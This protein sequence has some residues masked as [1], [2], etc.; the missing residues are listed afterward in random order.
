MEKLVSLYPDDATYQKEFATLL[1]W[2]ADTSRSQGHFGAAIEAR[3][4]QIS[5]LEHVLAGTRDS[6]ARSKLMSAH[7]GLGLLFNDTGRTDDALTQL[8]AALDEANQVIPIEPHNA[9]WKSIAADA[10]FSLAWTLLSSGQKEQ[11]EVQTTAGCA[12]AEELPQSYFAA[13][14]RFAAFCA[15]MRSRLALA[16][17]NANQA[18]AYAKQ[19]LSFARLQHTQDP[20]EDRYKLA[21]AYRL[22]GD[23]SQGAGDTADA[24][25]AWSAALSVLPPNVSEN[26]IEMNGRLQLL[27]RMNRA[28][29]AAQLEAR[30]NAIGY[31]GQ[32]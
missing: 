12:L 3:S 24:N 18:K 30:L 1:A 21:L 27:R 23:A 26:P 6:D 9:L 17:G 11:S 25:S 29:E 10:R 31:R 15:M 13:R 7:E 16:D 5:V 14:T 2:I 32:I 19:A 4:R 20:T 28:G 8:R 22:I